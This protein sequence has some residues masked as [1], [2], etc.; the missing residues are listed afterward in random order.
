MHVRAFV[1]VPLVEVNPNLVIPTI[2]KTVTEQLS[3]ITNEEKRGV[4]KW[5]KKDG[6]DG[7]KLTES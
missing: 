7:S 6:E 2:N 5:I 4:V 1:L 3:L